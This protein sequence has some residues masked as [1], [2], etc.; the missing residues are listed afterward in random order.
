MFDS[1][2]GSNS[3]TNLRVA[4]CGTLQSAR[5]FRFADSQIEASELRKEQSERR[6]TK[7]EDLLVDLGICSATTT[8]TTTSQIVATK[9][10]C[11]PFSKFQRCQKW[12][13]NAWQKDCHKE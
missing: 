7:R 12:Q 4:V 10:F 9:F 6:M 3:K 11:Y 8:T 13:L 1:E 2:K 5:E